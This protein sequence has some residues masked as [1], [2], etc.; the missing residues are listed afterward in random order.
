MNGAYRS[1][2]L[3][4]VEALATVEIHGYQSGVFGK[5]ILAPG[6]VACAGQHALVVHQR[7]QLKSI[8]LLSEGKHCPQ[9]AAIGALGDQRSCPGTF[10]RLATRLPSGDK[11][12]L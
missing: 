3:A 12:T 11:A 4:H 2:E 7:T 6:P 8:C 1:R 10:I 9:V 5:N